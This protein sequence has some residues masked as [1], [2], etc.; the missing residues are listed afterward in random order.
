[1]KE[2]ARCPWCLGNET[3]ME[4][5][6][7]EWGVPVYDD[8]KQFSNELVR[9]SYPI[10]IFPLKIAGEKL[11]YRITVGNFTSRTQAIEFA[12]RL[13]LDKLSMLKNH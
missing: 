3:Y 6:D 5:H 4:Y 10:S 11:W 7:H 12:K 8:A 2:K 13:K 9:K 1:M